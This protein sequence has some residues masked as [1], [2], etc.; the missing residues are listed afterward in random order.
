MRARE[1]A[2]GTDALRGA[3]GRHAAELY[4]DSYINTGKVSALLAELAD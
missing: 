4:I 1:G 3:Y 2:G